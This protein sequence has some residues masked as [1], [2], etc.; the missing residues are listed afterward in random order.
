MACKRFGSEQEQDF[1]AGSCDRTADESANATRT[2]NRVSHAA[3]WY[4]SRI[5]AA[6]RLQ[7]LFAGIELV[8]AS[9][10]QSYI[11]NLI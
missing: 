11:N 5:D 10:P 8:R 3:R 7:Q 9:M 4:A 2:E 1:G 6:S